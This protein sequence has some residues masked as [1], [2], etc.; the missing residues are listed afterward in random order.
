LSVPAIGDV[1]DALA[2]PGIVLAGAED[3]LPSTAGLYAIYGDQVAWK[4]LGLGVPPDRRPLY[5]GKAEDSVAVRDLRTHF[6]DGRTGSSTVR[7]SFAALLRE[8]LRLAAQPRNPEKP[9][10][11]AN[12]GLPPESDARL[13]PGCASTCASPSGRQTTAPRSAA[14]RSPCWLGGC[15]R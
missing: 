1:L 10:R 9:E 7:R 12:Y 13:R 3:H 5:V 2:G 4:A 8:P 15:R 14:S 11:F 6:G